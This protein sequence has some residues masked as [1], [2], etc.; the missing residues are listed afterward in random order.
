MKKIFILL[1]FISVGF[2]SCSASKNVRNTSVIKTSKKDKVVANAVK[3]K[4]V[5][6][7]F[8]G[9]TRKGMDCSGIVYVA[10]GEENITLPRVS[11]NI[12]KT[13]RKISLRNA[14]K[15][16]LIFFKTSK[17]GR[18]INHVGLIVSVKNGLVSFIHATTSKGVIVSSLNNSYWKKAFVKVNRVL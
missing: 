2:S 10:F 17:K 18:G 5:K 16:D 3:Y 12:A 6:Y 8:G 4:G 14:Q 13:G 7:K 11:R 9:T 1:V 15:G